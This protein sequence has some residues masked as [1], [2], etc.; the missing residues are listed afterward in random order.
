VELLDAAGLAPGGVVR[1]GSPVPCTDPGVYAVSMDPDPSRTT[2]TLDAAPISQSAIDELLSLRPELTVDGKRPT[3]AELAARLARFWLPD[4]VLL[5]I[6]LA[7]TSLVDRVTAYY[8]TPLGARSP[9]AG[10]WFLK[11]L[12][13][14]LPRWV[15]WAQSTRPDDSEHAMLKQFSGG[16][17]K[18]SLRLLLDPDRPFP[19]AN[20]EWPPGVRKRHGIAGARAP[21]STGVAARPTPRTAPRSATAERKKMPAHTGPPSRSAPGEQSSSLRSQQVTASDRDV[22]QIRVPSVSKRAFPKEAA[23]I[24]VRVQGRDVMAGWNPRVGPDRERSGALRVGRQVLTELV[25]LGTILV[26]TP[27]AGGPVELTSR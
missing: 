26:I 9:H 21:R 4:E 6:G 19:F 24:S 11:T 27:I 16:V 3:Q 13:P 1:W 8:K 17:T 7:G 5:Y 10:G 25:P 22:G 14:E 23:T 2:S 12:D 18:A 20:L 15:H